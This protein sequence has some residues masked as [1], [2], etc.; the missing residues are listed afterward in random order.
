MHKCIYLLLYCSLLNVLFIY[1]HLCIYLFKSHS[2]SNLLN[3]F[4]FFIY[5]SI[6]FMNSVLDVSPAHHQ[7]ASSP[8][9]LVLPGLYFIWSPFQELIT[10]TPVTHYPEATLTCSLRAKSCFAMVNISEWFCFVSVF[11]YLGLFSL[12]IDCFLPALT[13]C[14]FWGLHI[15]LV[16]AIVFAGVWPCLF[17]LNPLANKAEFRSLLHWCPL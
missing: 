8:Y 6:Y 16:C 14:L 2:F 1:L 17:V 9:C 4:Y 15:C 7:R 12:F 10:L 3:I 13:S 11:I 5:S